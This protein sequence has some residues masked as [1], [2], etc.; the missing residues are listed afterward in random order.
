MLKMTVLELIEI[1]KKENPDA[2]VVMASQINNGKI[3]LATGYSTG[4]Y[5]HLK[6]KLYEDSSFAGQD[7]ICLWPS[8]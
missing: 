7:A 5:D 1:L 6:Q 4:V 2:I 3:Y 8:F